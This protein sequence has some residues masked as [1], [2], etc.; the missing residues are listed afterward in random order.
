MGPAVTLDKEMVG[1]D[2]VAVAER[3]VG[4]KDGKVGTRRL[5]VGF[6]SSRIRSQ[7]AKLVSFHRELG[8]LVE[9]YI[10]LSQSRH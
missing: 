1:A 10:V 3:A 4:A 6:S 8:M 5:V 7:I 9:R 2:G